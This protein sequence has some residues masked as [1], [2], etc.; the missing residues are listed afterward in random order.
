MERYI[1]ILTLLLIAGCTSRNESPKYIP[2]GSTDTIHAEA[3]NIRKQ[4]TKTDTV[5]KNEEIAQKPVLYQNARFKEVT[6]T[7]M[8]ENT[9]EI[10]GKAQI[11]EASFSWIIEDGHEELQKGFAT[12]DAGAPE[13][14]NFSF[15]VTASKK[16]SG[17]TLHLILFETSAKDGSRQY[18][19]PLLLY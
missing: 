17:S 16:R 1:L 18:E 13:W 11:F 9:F 14:G 6:V 2:S 4:D 15:T 3:S 10:K 19:L 8:G 7:K 12:T 5:S